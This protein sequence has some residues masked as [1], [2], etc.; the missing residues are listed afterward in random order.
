[1]ELE[2]GE[3][4]PECIGAEAGHLRGMLGLAGG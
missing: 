2:I 3:A 1:L 4:L